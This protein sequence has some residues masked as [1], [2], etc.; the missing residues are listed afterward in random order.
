MH[1]PGENI[2]IEIKW[3]TQWIMSARIPWNG[4][5]SNI[6]SDIKRFEIEC[7]GQKLKQISIVELIGTVIT[8]DK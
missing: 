3:W 2:L 8:N 4:K 1:A 5:I 6:S 7:S